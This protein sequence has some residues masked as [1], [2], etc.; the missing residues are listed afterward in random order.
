LVGA[1]VGTL[2]VKSI[3]MSREAA[4]ISTEAIE[5]RKA[6]LEQTDAVARELGKLTIVSVRT[7]GYLAEGEP[8]AK[9]LDAIQLNSNDVLALQRQLR[10][11]WRRS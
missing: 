7:L 1:L 8:D 9:L 4:M 2:G 5:Q 10:E 11:L 3:A 6:Y